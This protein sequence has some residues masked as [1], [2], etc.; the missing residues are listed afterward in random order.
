MINVF[1]VT[2]SVCAY[3]IGSIPTGYIVAYLK[4]IKD[5]RQHGS[6]NIGATN[7]SRVLGIQYFFLIFFLDVAKAFLFFHY[8][9]PYFTP[10]YLYFFGCI[11]LLGNTCSFFLRGT[12]GKGVATLC[13]VLCALNLTAIGF[14]LAIWCISMAI[15]KTVGIASVIAAASLLV[16]ACI[17]QDGVFILF[18]CIVSAWIIWLH[19][20]NIRIYWEKCCTKN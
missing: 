18:S 16:Y 4:G 19:R 9:K 3:L 10:D 15:V 17:L 5:I 13:G 8:I 6:G 12:G 1:V 11:F 14:L 7:V 2:T 20:S